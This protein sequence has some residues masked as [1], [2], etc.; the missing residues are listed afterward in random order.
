VRV[1]TALIVCGGGLQ[2]HALI[3]SLRALPAMRILVA[4]CHTDN[5]GRFDVDGYFVAPPLAE[6]EAFAAFLHR[7]CRDE[8]VGHLFPITDLEFDLIERERAA[9]ESAGTRVWLSNA[10]TVAVARDK[11]ALAAW[12]GAR[13][14]PGLPTAADPGALPADGPL[15]GKPRAGWG[16]RGIVHVGSC[17]EALAL[18]PANREALAWQPRL[19]GFDEYS[20]DLAV[21]G[22]DAVSPMYARRRLRTSGGFAVLCEP[23]TDAGVVEVA[24]RTAHALAA[25]GALGVLNLQVLVADGQ[26]WVSDFNARAGMSLPLTLAAGGNPA[27]LLFGA[28][29]GTAATGPNVRTVRHLNERRLQREVAP[30]VRGVVFDLDDT[31]LDQKHWIVA[32]LRGLWQAEQSWL[33]AER[34]FMRRMLAILEQG[35]RA[36]LIDAY[37][38]ERGHDDGQRQ[39]LIERYRAVR[40]TQARLYDDVAGTLVQLRRRGLRLGLLT[41][42]P[43]ASQRMKLESADLAGAFD[44]IVLTGEL[45]H[46]KPH[47]SVFEAAARALD[48]APDALVMVG[49][50]LY[51]DSLGA[52]E[53]G[54]AHAFHIQRAGAFFHFDTEL[55]RPWLPEGRWT[56]L[57]SLPELAWHLDEAE[58]AA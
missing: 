7:V 17:A 11:L 14:L 15:I 12:L 33:E 28:A 42:N 24:T 45:R 6:R 20:I 35:E 29:C 26:L 8:A 31:L 48:L 46:T 23:S 19:E 25:Q 21:A 39:R 27:A 47:A 30:G 4:D 40:P 9:L 51:R 16:G 1:T 32:K 55:A 49:D 50:H 18:P 43:A 37:C 3:K 52:L 57:H 2:G 13:G 41:D 10:A 53:A 22:P 36:R 34:A 38:A 5:I 56:V 44:A 54:F 58:A